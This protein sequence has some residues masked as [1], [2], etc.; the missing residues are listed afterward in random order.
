MQLDV[1]CDGKI[2]KDDLTEHF[3]TLMT[4]EDA[5]IEA[6][7][8]MAQVDFSKNG[9]IDYTEYLCACTDPSIL[10]SERNVQLAFSLI[11]TD[12]DGFITARDL[13]M[14]LAI[15][16]SDDLDVWQASIRQITKKGNLDFDTF[17][18]YLIT[19]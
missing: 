13:Q 11:D 16:T 19:N 6:S 8:I 17:R 3:A 14:A 9:Y 1:D 7:R 12:D 18:A 15:T 10:L 5:E 4:E 2:G